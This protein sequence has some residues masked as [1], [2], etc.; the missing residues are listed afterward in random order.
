MALLHAE[1]AGQAAAAGDPGDRRAG[2]L[3]QRLVGGPAEDGVVVAVRLGDHLDPGE[4]GQR[5]L[6]ALDELGEASARPGRAPASSAASL[7]SVARQD[8]SSPTTGTPELD[9]RRAAWHRA[10]HDR[11]GLVELAGA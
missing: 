8:G 2:A 5:Q 10:R 6:A 7:R 1:V 11:A 9:V 3:E 4:V